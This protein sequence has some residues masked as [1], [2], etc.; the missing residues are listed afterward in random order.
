[1]LLIFPIQRVDR[2]EPFNLLLAAVF[3]VAV[4]AYFRFAG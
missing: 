3:V 4:A 2:H 1:L